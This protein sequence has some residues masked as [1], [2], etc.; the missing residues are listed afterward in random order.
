MGEKGENGKEEKGNKKRPEERFFMNNSQGTI[1]KGI[2]LFNFPILPH[3]YEA[4]G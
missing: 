2:V 4:P 3:R 1:Y